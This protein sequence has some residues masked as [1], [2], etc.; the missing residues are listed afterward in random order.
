M[1]E[2]VRIRWIDPPDPKPKDWQ[3]SV[4]RVGVDE[5]GEIWIPARL[6]SD[7]ESWT[8][9]VSSEPMIFD[10]V[11][12]PYVRAG[13]WIN[14]IQD[15]PR[16]AFVEQVR[17]DILKRVRAVSDRENARQQNRETA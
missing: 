11:G 7:D 13:W 17:E 6:L 9:M 3:E 1:S 15:P 12:S 5:T 10:D 14:Q 4:G 2:P 8:A 16:R